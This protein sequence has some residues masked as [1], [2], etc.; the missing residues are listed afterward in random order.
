MGED[1]DFVFYPPYPCFDVCVPFCILST[2]LTHYSKR[3]Q[4]FT[5]NTLTDALRSKFRNLRSFGRAVDDILISFQ[6]T[7]SWFLCSFTFLMSPCVFLVWDGAAS[8]QTAGTYSISLSPAAV[9]S[10]LLPFV[11]VTVDLQYSSFRNSSLSALRSNSF[12]ARTA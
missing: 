8:E 2:L 11:S 10:Q 12:S 6:M 3:T 1:Y 4:T 7:S 5:T 9:S